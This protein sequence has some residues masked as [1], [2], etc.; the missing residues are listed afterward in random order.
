MPLRPKEPFRITDPATAILWI[1]LWIVIIGTLIVLQGCVV[2]K[3]TI[4]I[5][6][7]EIGEFDSSV[8]SF[9]AGST[10]NADAS[11]S[12]T[13]AVNANHSGSGGGSSW[14]STIWGMIREWF[15]VAKK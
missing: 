6:H 14:V 15:G 12:A 11:T 5:E 7:A 13:L 10:V 3:P 8:R 4:R 1:V 2:N 9:S